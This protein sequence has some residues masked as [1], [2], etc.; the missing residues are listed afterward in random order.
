[1]L[2]SGDRVLVGVSGGPDSMALLHLLVQAPF[3]ETI[4]LG[5][6]HL[7]H[8]LRGKTAEKEAKFVR[9]TADALGFPCHVGRARVVNVERKLGLSTEEA[10]HRVRYA[11]FRKVMA[12]GGYTKLALGH[13]M[14]DNAEQL[15]LVLLR[16]TG[17]RG[18]SGIAPVKGNRII[19][20]LIH[21][22]RAQIEAYVEAENISCVRDASNDDFRFMRN[23]IRHDLLPLL[24]STYNPRIGQHLNRLADLVRTEESWIGEWVA[25]EYPKT[26]IGRKHGEVALSVNQLQTSHTALMRR[27]LRMALEE[28][29]G[30]LRRIDFSHIHSISRL[31]ADGD[32]K[33]CHLPG[34]LR[35]RR[36]GDRLMLSILPRDRR[37]SAAA[38]IERAAGVEKVIE[39]PIPGNYE[40]REM[41][42]GLRF[43]FCSR[44]QLPPW[45]AMEP[46]RAYLDFDCL[47]LPLTVRRPA[48]G[49]RFRP[50]GAGGR[51]KLKKFFI[52]HRISRS[53]RSKTPVL[54]DRRGIVWLIGQRIDERVKVTPRT[55]RILNTEFFLLDTR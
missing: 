38:R 33:Q 14:D 46:N 21:V 30:N 53:N 36:D 26:V 4:E 11:F 19:R 37:R 35:A 7:N 16:G 27:L 8:C 29:A 18:L 6:A 44:G 17:P 2:T 12:D 45:T 20:P 9:R 51:Q 52:D 5:V 1:M 23:R 41:G 40:I 54:A 55:S 48:P 22:R 34:G 31:L 49:E 13:H 39:G 24:T 50:L 43:S 3:D 25:K 47:S 32:G 42:I 10:A 28:V 15:L